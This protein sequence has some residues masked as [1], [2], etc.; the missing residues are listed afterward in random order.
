MTAGRQIGVLCAGTDGIDGNSP[1]AGAVADG[2]TLIRGRALN[3]NPREFFEQ[4][5][6][7][8]LF[9]KL[10]DAIVTGHGEQSAGPAN[11]DSGTLILEHEHLLFSK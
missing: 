7:H 6:S 5:D 1:A 11:F 8:A 10:D 2:E 9:V 4:S 3:M